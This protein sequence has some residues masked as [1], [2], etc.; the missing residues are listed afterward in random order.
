MVA[1]H[2][3]EL[4]V[5]LPEVSMRILFNGMVFISNDFLINVEYGLS[6]R[7]EKR[8]LFLDSYVQ[9]VKRFYFDACKLLNANSFVFMHAKYEPNVQ[10]CA[11]TVE[12]VSKPYLDYCTKKYSK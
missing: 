8:A 5:K 4:A 12:I 9:F 3:C 1:K 10:Y 2:L 6:S 11:N 7:K